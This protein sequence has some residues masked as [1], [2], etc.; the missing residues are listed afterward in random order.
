MKLTNKELH[1][2]NGGAS[3][4][5]INALS[6]AVSTIFKIGQSIGSSI[7]RVFSRSYC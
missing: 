1:E 7:R 6:R 4:T 3:A 5:M 2:I